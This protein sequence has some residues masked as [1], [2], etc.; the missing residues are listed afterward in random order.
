MHA[1]VF[2]TFNAICWA[3]AASGAVLEVGAVPSPDTLLM[4][5]ALAAARERVGV[6]LEQ[7]SE[8][9][10]CPIL[11]ADAHNLS[12][13]ETGHF[14]VVLCNSVLEHDAT[15]WLSLAEIRRVAKPGGLVVIGVPGY[16]LPEAG[17]WRYLA[18]CLARLPLLMNSW[19]TAAEAYLASTP[20]L[21]LHDYPRDY[22]RFS[23]QA[24]KDILL[25]GLESIEIRRVL[26]P[27]RFV[28]AGRLPHSD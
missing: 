18:I 16:A 4:L 24:C 17:Q 26:S 15:F 23:E 14:D 2:S 3:Q 5:P 25:G 11:Q 6:N 1:A 13:F 19:K 27:P 20:V 7:P 12:C 10:G 8:I 22:Y 9:G 21:G 28:A